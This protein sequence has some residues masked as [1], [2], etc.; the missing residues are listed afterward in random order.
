MCLT[1]Y[2]SPRP[3]IR[4]PGTVRPQVETCDIPPMLR[5]WVE[6][7]QA[8]GHTKYLDAM[9]RQ[10]YNQLLAHRSCEAKT[11]MNMPVNHFGNPSGTSR[12]YSELDPF[13]CCWS[14]GPVG[15]A[16]IPRWSYFT[17]PEGILV[18]L[19]GPSTFKGEMKGI[20]LELNI[21]SLYPF[22]DTT[23]ISVRPAK[24]CDFTLGLRIPAWS[25]GVSVCV[26]G[27]SWVQRAKP[28][29]LL[30]IKRL[31]NANDSVELKFD[32][33]VRLRELSGFEPDYS[34]IENGP[35]VL[36]MERFQKQVDGWCYISPLLEND[37]SPLLQ[38][39]NEFEPSNHFAP[40]WT[41]SGVSRY[42]IEGSILLKTNSITLVPF[43]QAG[44][45][46]EPYIASFPSRRALDLLPPRIHSSRV[47]MVPKK[48]MLISSDTQVV[49]NEAFKAGD[50]DTSTKWCSEDGS[51]PHWLDFKFPKPE[52][53][54]RLI[55]HFSDPRNHPLNFKL[56]AEANRDELKP[57]V[58]ISNYK[59][60]DY[61]WAQFNSQYT[62]KIRLL[63]ESCSGDA[64]GVSISEVDFYADE[65]RN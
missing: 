48:E 10:L 8:T 54:T 25:R 57:F 45:G 9:E 40:R 14:M 53:I 24:P 1:G 44:R 26:N 34:T 20:R 43:C 50:G 35:L 56:L 3:N 47:K 59:P 42:D 64:N 5:W 33:M 39:E 65:S 19:Y 18:N 36:A 61:F 12:R 2:T 27:N 4:V 63:I 17:F 15:I 49:G 58:S 51:F 60:G 11:F 37:G 52:N 13:N 31:W 16:D 21:K 23:K 46:N 30:K 7:F 38:L 62:D 6:L 55:V 32:K 29:T 28:G 22:T 41:T